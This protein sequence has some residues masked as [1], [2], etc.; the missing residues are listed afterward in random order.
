M[1]L[2]PTLCAT[3]AALAFESFAATPP[4]RVALPLMKSPPK[5]DGQVHEPEWAGATRIIGFV[6]YRKGKVT[7]RDGAFWVGCD[8]ERLYIAVVTEAPPGD[9]LLTRAVPDGERDIHALVRDDTIELWV[10][11]HLG[12][13]AG[14]RRRFQIMVNA[15]GTLYDRSYDDANRENPVDVTWRVKWQFASKVVDG[16]W[17]VEAAIPLACMGAA[18]DLGHPWGLRVVRNWQ[19]P[20]GQSHWATSTGAFYHVSTMPVVEWAPDAPVAQMVSLHEG[21]KEPR[22]AVRIHNPGPQPIRAKVFLSDAWSMDPPRELEQAVA[23]G[24]GQSQTVALAG[25]DAGPEGDHRTII[26]VTSPD[27]A[28]VFFFRDFQW[29]MHRPQAVWTVEKQQRQAVDLK[30]KHYP[31][32]RK[33]K[34]KV[35]LSALETRDQV[36]SARVAV[37][38]KGQTAA[39]AEHTLRFEDA[40]AESIFDVPELPDGEYEIAAYL[41][42]GPG[43]PEKPVVAE[44]ERR[45]FPW[46]GNKL[47]LS[48]AVIPPFEPLEVK[49][50]SVRCVLREY[51]LNPAGLWDQITADGRPLLAGP[52]RWEIRSGGKALALRAAAPQVETA[53]AHRVVTRSRWRAGGL[54]AEVRGEYDYDGMCKVWLSLAA[55][56]QTVDR[57]S[58]VAPLRNDMVRY[59]HAC[60]DGLRHNFSGRA[61]AGEGRVWD[62]SKGNKVRIVGTFYPYIYLGHAARG[63]AWFADSDRD[64]V[65]DD[66]TPT[67]EV[68]RRGQVVELRVHLVTKPFRPTR[69]HRIEFGLQ[70][71]PVKPMPQQPMGWRK[72]RCSKV[73]PGLRPFTIFGATLYWGCVGHDLYPRGGDL[74]IYEWI[75]DARKNGKADPAFIDPWMQGYAPYEELGSKRWK[76]LVAHIRNTARRAPMFPRSIGATMTPYTNARGVGFHMFE[77]PTFQD[78]WINFPYYNRAKKGGVGYDIT[79]TKSYRDFAMYR[80]KQAMVCMDGVY[81]DNVY[82]SA[83]YDTVACRAWVDE[84]GRIHP[85][86]GL[87]DMRALIRRAAILYHEQGRPGVFIPH[88]TNTNIV[89]TLAFANCNLDWEWRYGQTDFQ[90]R[91]SPDLTVAQTIG[92][93]TGNVPLILSG[94]FRDRKHPKYPWVMRTRLGVTLVHEIR[95]WDYGPAQEMEFLKKLHAFGY[96]EADCAVFNY[97]DDGHPVRVA[98]IDART[99]AMARGGKALVIVTDYGDGGAATVKLDAKPLGI[100]AAAKA[101]DFETG[102]AI[103]GDAS[104][105]LRF[106]MKKHDF[107]AMVVE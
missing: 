82:M 101:K 8:G 28:R 48:N 13:T 87:W 69:P 6:A 105:G 33:V 85:S 34:V 56:A 47:G 35:D 72:W 104:S 78:E 54:A 27:G 84:G 31:T 40:A 20:R 46:E 66:H 42:G 19:R 52:M 18:E 91:F 12:K 59:M 79:P 63:L 107:K 98:G 16:S 4:P 89:P 3:V 102:E 24:P 1:N 99:I 76:Y 43:V 29:N 67:V 25:R 5:I 26:R 38:G 45:H 65:L 15:R 62:S 68:V 53:L 75:R 106:Q 39:L 97:W 60:G 58:L 61:P 77:W 36:E 92:R 74:S 22:V 37:R 51:R 95:V 55:S 30:F 94:G 93:K 57:V 73:L 83:N 50:G 100:P 103:A 2:H 96:G 14:D 90:D 17:H 64:W 21:H 10:H 11:P 32:Y 81:W 88:M 86:M 41:Q 70:A 9:G 23:L 7:A 44:F 80:Y 71:T 49:A